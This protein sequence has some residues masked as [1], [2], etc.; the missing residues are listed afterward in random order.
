VDRILVRVWSEFGEQSARMLGRH[1][2]HLNELSEMPAVGDWVALVKLPH[3][4]Y[5]I[6]HALLPR[7]SKFSRQAAG[8]ATQEQ[9]VAANIDTALI[10]NGLDGD[11][12]F[13]RIERY[14]ALCKLGN[15]DPVLVLN[16]ADLC[17]DLDSIRQQIQLLAPEVKIVVLSTLTGLGMDQLAAL[18]VSGKTLALLGSSGV[19]KSSIVNHLLGETTLK[20]TSVRVKDSRGR[21]TTTYRQL[22]LLDNGALLIDTPGLR[23]LH[24]WNE[25]EEDIDSFDDI[26]ELSSQCRFTNCTHE[27][28]PHCA[29]RKAISD[30]TMTESRYQSYLKLQAENASQQIRQEEHLRREHEKKLHGM[31]RKKQQEKRKKPGF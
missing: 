14:L 31:Y 7:R 1:Q 20:T 16:K 29:V 8:K 27:R 6:V 23:E 26:E 24:L 25:Q 19:G 12:N 17:S 11:L 10:V 9:V 28:E 22:F 4:E 18:L 13:R 3:E 21:H 5:P 2:Y 15:V 30:G